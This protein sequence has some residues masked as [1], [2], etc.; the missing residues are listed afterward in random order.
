MMCHT[1]P[2]SPG[3]RN[4]YG[5]FLE[6]ELLAGN[7]IVGAMTVAEP[8]DSDGDGFTNLAEIL[9]RTFPGDPSDFPIAS[10]PNISV[11]PTTLAFGAVNTGANKAMTVTVSNTGNA[12]LTVSGVTLT[13][14]LDFSLQ[15]PPATPFSV[16]ANGSVTL[17]AQYAPT[18][19]GADSGSI[20]I[21]SDDPD[22]PS[23]SVSLSGTGAASAL[24]ASPLA[25]DFGQITVGSSKSLLVTINNTG[26]SAGTVTSLTLGGS[27]DF[28]L[29]AAAPA[30]PFTVSPGS[31]VTVP[32]NYTPGVAG[33]AS[34][35]L[36]IGTDSTSTPTLTVSL[37]G[38]GGVPQTAVIGMTPSSLAF[39]QVPVGT[40]KSMMVTIG[41]IGNAAFSVS[42]LALS[43]S[44]D[45]AL[46]A[47]AP[48]TP[49]SVAPGAQVT[50]PVVYT[51]SNEG[52]D[53]GA[54]Q[55]TSN[56]TNQTQV[57]V[58]LAGGGITS[59]LSLAPTAQDFGTV[60][61]GSSASRTVTVTN[62][63]GL[64][65]SVTVVSFS[66]SADFDL[67]AGAPATPFTLA[68][69]A[70]VILPL[71]FA[72]S[73]AGPASGQLN[74]A[75]DD[76]KSPLLTTA[77]SGNGSAPPVA[78]PNIAVNPSA[79]A[80]G[81]V[82]A[83]S[84]GTLSVTI[85]NTGNAVLTVGS[86]AVSGSADFALDPAVPAAP[87]LVA[88]GASV[89]VTILYL[90]AAAGADTGALQIASDDADTPT[91]AVSLTGEGTQSALGVSPASLSFGSIT[92]GASKTLSVRVTNS[93]NA[94]AAIT[95]V[96]I[97]GN[98]AFTLNSAV[99][100][101]PATVAA[102]ASVDIAVNYTPAAEGSHT[103]TLEI[104]SSDPRTPQWS[105]ALDGSAVKPSTTEPVRLNIGRFSVTKEI[106]KRGEAVQ[107]RLS[108]NNIGK[109]DQPRPATVTGRQ[110]NVTIYNQ[111]MTV[112]DPIGGRAT[113]HSFPSYT[114]QTNGEITWT[115]TLQD[116][117]ADRDWA[118]ARTK[119][120]LHEDEEGDEHDERDLV[121]RPRRS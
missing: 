81:K 65:A 99:P 59:H 3:P 14:S 60:M 105:V 5:S 44:T 21:A 80:F 72:P 69:N 76:P 23:A 79:L 103:G 29:G 96:A 52:N 67:G 54:L 73:A 55:I 119:V 17:S 47:G 40:S 33:A 115:V 83:G 68:A 39:G 97:T 12:A 75:S 42:A 116:D 94:S 91:A 13:G 51:A 100:S 45:F 108:V 11:S 49:F 64:A 74:L 121:S 84:T 57:S 113:T 86:L 32:V 117:D 28:A 19:I 15:S 82:A 107:I 98:S 24:A 77:L 31:S 1:T 26:T 35:S 30:T 58:T 9:A 90:P 36:Q 95:V 88:A 48:A 101:M 16:A 61:V 46:A 8:L 111:T 89:S 6:D 10:A 78:A 20:V 87:F 2:T 110:N 56:A 71:V 85:Q 53:S 4:P 7:T 118:M 41:N 114:P 50:V 70:S 43:G 22:S 102:G 66:G 109:V 38:T 34:G 37:A 25:L 104:S 120:K 93:G 106:E 63:G 62:S 112:S 27:A 18:G 92:V